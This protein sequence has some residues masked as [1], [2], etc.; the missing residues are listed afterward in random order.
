MTMSMAMAKAL[1]I[2]GTIGEVCAFS[3][4]I[5]HR[6]CV[7]NKVIISCAQILLLTSRPGSI[8]LS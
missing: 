5:K 2:I 8:G 3:D 6:E 7:R 1:E 4:E